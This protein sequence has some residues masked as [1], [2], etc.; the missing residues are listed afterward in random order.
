M[1]IKKIKKNN[2][3]QKGGIIDVFINKDIDILSIID[4]II[5][6]K[7]EKIA[8][9]YFLLHNKEI[10]N[11]DDFLTDLLPK[12]ITYI[13]N[14]TFVSFKECMIDLLQGFVVYKYNPNDQD[15]RKFLY[16][17]KLI[18]KL[19]NE[20]NNINFGN[21]GSEAHILYCIDNPNKILRNKCYYNDI[22]DGYLKYYNDLPEETKKNDKD[23][24]YTI[25]D[26]FKKIGFDIA[27]YIHV[28]VKNNFNP[29]EFEG[30]SQ[31]TKTRIIN[32]F[33]DILKNEF[34][35]L[36]KK[37]TEGDILSTILKD[38]ELKQLYEKE[39]NEGL[40]DE[41]KNLFEQKKYNLYKYG[42]L[43]FKG[44]SKKIREFASFKNSVLMNPNESVSLQNASKLYDEYRNK[45]SP[46]QSL[47]TQVRTQVKK[48]YVEKKETSIKMP[49][50]TDLQTGVSPP[51]QRKPLGSSSKSKKDDKPDKL[52]SL[53]KT[54][55]SKSNE[56]KKLGK[57]QETSKT[58]LPKN[59]FMSITFSEDKDKKKLAEDFFEIFKSQTKDKK[60]LYKQSY[61]VLKDFSDKFQNQFRKS[62]REDTFDF[63]ANLKLLFE[64]IDELR[65]F[66]KFQKVF[67]LVFKSELDKLKPEE[68]I[69]FY[70]LH[71]NI[72]KKILKS[73]DDTNDFNEILKLQKLLKTYLFFFNLLRDD[74]LI[75]LK[76]L[77]SQI[78]IKKYINSI[79]SI[80]FKKINELYLIGFTK[81]CILGHLEGN[82]LFLSLFTSIFK[83]NQQIQKRLLDLSLQSK[84]PVLLSKSPLRRLI[85]KP[86]EKPLLKMPFESP[87]KRTI[88]SLSKRSKVS[89]ISSEAIKSFVAR[90]ESIIDI[91][92]DVYEK[93]ELELEP[94]T[95]KSVEEISTLC[96][97]MFLQ[98]KSL[99]SSIISCYIPKK[100]CENSLVSF[101]T[102]QNIKLFVSMKS[103]DFLL[104]NIQQLETQKLFYKYK[105]RF[106]L[107]EEEQKTLATQLVI[108]E[109][110]DITT[111]FIQYVNEYLQTQKIKDLNE[112]FK[113]YKMVFG[114]I[115]NYKKLEYKPQMKPYSKPQ[116]EDILKLLKFEKDLM[117]TV[118]PK[119]ENKVTSMHPQ[120]PSSLLNQ[121][122]VFKLKDMLAKTKSIMVTDTEQKLNKSEEIKKR[123]KTITDN[124]LNAF[125]YI[126]NVLN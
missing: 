27:I 53:S 99:A 66:E 101:Y 54:S 48:E 65:E 97:Q 98:F 83:P 21:Y 89:Q 123:G 29:L 90:K 35:S 87:L 110:D 18:Y 13:T 122:T 25:E 14:L 62:L 20:K 113:V 50:K 94:V 108:K 71:Q 64:S 86:T 36:F 24:K 23:K 75:S 68:L 6:K 7:A 106:H 44:C 12:I 34:K 31:Q 49:I 92:I 76:K 15:T 104:K 67:E 73:I 30:F 91:P 96:E 107:L 52:P 8:S 81:L 121:G 9:Y 124:F 126:Y 79:I 3:K 1:K 77:K 2:K 19:N 60:L 56:R 38:E 37:S 40:E 11:I 16:L 55:F 116:E 59:I 93:S 118:F 58:F 45:Y 120:Y 42:I 72:I 119:Q 32:N 105:S 22:L 78:K 17:G 95:K 33:T 100:R 63:S 125:N 43:E 85:T 74:L 82:K 69:Q 109:K 28:F 5:R 51:K 47:Q 117:K 57:P 114:S 80:E 84:M 111:T 4:C 41:E 102:S 39:K 88:N 10:N 46:K 115:K 70:K 103:I 26:I 61:F 112:F